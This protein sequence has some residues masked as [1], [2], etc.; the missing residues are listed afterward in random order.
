MPLIVN[1]E[2]VPE[3]AIAQEAESLLQR[4]R[5]L[6]E[7]QRR[8]N[9]FT[10]EVMQQRAS[11]WARENLIERTLM[12]QEASKDPEPVP[13]EVF[14]KAYEGILRRFGGQ[15]KLEES[16][17]D[18]EMIRGE[19]ELTVKL[20]RLLG[21]VTSQV[22]PP[23]SKD[24]AAYY[25]THR[26]NWKIPESI[27]AAHIVKHTSE[28]VT[29][30]DAQAA[31]EDLHQRL[32]KGETFE[33]IADESSDCPGNGGDLGWFPRGKMVEDFDEVV[34]KMEPG[35]VS[36]PFRSVF[37]FHIAKVFEKK[38]AS[39]RPLNE[40]KGEIEQQMRRERETKAVEDF[41]DSL[42]ENAEIE[43]TVEEE[44]A[45]TG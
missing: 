15:E 18:E 13:E 26:E 6:S 16:E 32:S 8:E 40:V 41:V 9:G 39:V 35:Q 25:R 23:K 36:E 5:Q 30:K 27:R 34:F 1:G 28:D 7:E 14:D 45:T 19:A 43:N 24:V 29:A 21:K 3:P 17:V 4:F 38:P 11:E 33:T 42:R 12:R 10:E 31:I 37:G 44:V 22:K 2:T 20:D